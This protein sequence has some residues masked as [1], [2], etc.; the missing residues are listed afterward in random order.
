[1]N[2]RIADARA[3]LLGGDSRYD[4]L[5]LDVFNGDTTPAH[6][7]SV[8][9]LRL[10]QAR[11]ADGGVMA[12]NLMGS[13]GKNS[14]ITASIIRTLEAVFTHVRVYPAFARRGKEQAGNFV[15]IA[16][17]GAARVPDRDILARATLSPW[18]EAV[19]RPALRAPVSLPADVPFMLLTDDHN[20]ADARDLWLKERVR[21]EILESTPPALLLGTAP[22]RITA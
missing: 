18:V 4:F 2:V 10:A 17:D 13:L 12:I 6:L 5:I 11:L 19:V 20:P 16:H 7:L 9:A 1:V 22:G 3:F 21:R 8:E 15:L 14:F